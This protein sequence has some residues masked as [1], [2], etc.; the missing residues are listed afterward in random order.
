MSD[1]STLVPVRCA[2]CRQND[3][4]ALITIND[5]CPAF[6]CEPCIAKLEQ[7]VADYNAARPPSGARR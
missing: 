5:D 3:T 7:F 6:A 2:F 4:T 1:A